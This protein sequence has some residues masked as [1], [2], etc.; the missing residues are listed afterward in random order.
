MHFIKSKKII[1]KGKRK[2]NTRKLKKKSIKRGGGVGS[3]RPLKEDTPK[4]SKTSKAP[5]NKR[6][7]S[8][9]ELSTIKSVSLSPVPS[10]PIFNSTIIPDL[11]NIK[12]IKPF[13]PPSNNGFIHLVTINDNMKAI[14]KS[15]QTLKQKEGYLMKPDNLMYEYLVGQYINTLNNRFPC[16][17]QTYGLYKYPD[18]PDPTYQ[19]LVQSKKSGDDITSDDIKNIEKVNVNDENLSDALNIACKNDKHIAIL[20]QYLPN[21]E[22]FRNMLDKNKLTERDIITSLYQVYF[23]LNVLKNKFTHYD[24]HARNVQLYEVSGDK[25]IQYHYHYHLNSGKVVLV[26]FKSK[27]LVKIIDYSRCFFYQNKNF[28]SGIISQQL[29]KAIDCI[30][31]EKSGKQKPAGYDFGF[32]W[33]IPPPPPKNEEE[34]EE[35]N[36]IVS[37]QLN[38]SHDLRLLNDIK[39]I[40]PNM[41]DKPIL[42]TFL[43]NVYYKNE[44]GT[45]PVSEEHIKDKY[46]VN[47][48]RAAKKLITIITDNKPDNKPYYNEAPTETSKLLCTLDIY[49][50]KKDDM[51]ITYPK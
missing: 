17:L 23:V 24:L 48:N 27:Y 42:K 28:S 39:H 37:T 38:I 7:S 49:S 32:Q 3:S 44:F 6:M 45:P 8:I 20:L 19:K 16:F 25:Y 10:I 2:N 47:V 13:G 18:D 11:S 41:D 33:L 22:S 5:S 51:Q 43:N 1:R 36:Y 30:T 50:H 26:S 35:E 21:I 15:T 4:A 31:R 29:N 46:I 9:P 14:L 12:E 40:L 34:E